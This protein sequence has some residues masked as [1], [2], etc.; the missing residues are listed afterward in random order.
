MYFNLQREDKLS[1]K[2]LMPG[3]KVSVIWRFHCIEVCPC[4]CPHQLWSF[5]LYFLQCCEDTATAVAVCYCW[6]VALSARLQSDSQRELRKWHTKVCFVSL[7]SFPSPT[8][9]CRP[10]AN[11][12]TST[13][14]FCFTSNK[15][16]YT[17]LYT[18][19]HRCMYESLYY[20]YSCACGK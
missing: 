2:N 8:I 12:L 13:K 3:P 15:P 7:P 14:A 16:L 10:A 5:P 17:L 19:H 20:V 11:M 4:T 6:G 1:I 18:H 9:E